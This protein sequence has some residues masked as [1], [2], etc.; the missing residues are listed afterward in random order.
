MSF[1]WPFAYF[2]RLRYV[3]FRECIWFPRK[4]HQAVAAGSSHSVL[5][6]EGKVYAMGDGHHGQ[7]GTGGFTD[8]SIGIGGRYDEVEI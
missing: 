3:S 7:L 8:E 2:Q 5:I 1:L 4:F 6:A